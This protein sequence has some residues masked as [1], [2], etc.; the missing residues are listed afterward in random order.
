M[1]VAILAPIV[2]P[3]IRGGVVV[4]GEDVET[5]STGSWDSTQRESDQ[6]FVRGHR[7]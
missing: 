7:D 5:G 3:H 4:E 1:S 6:K 2:R